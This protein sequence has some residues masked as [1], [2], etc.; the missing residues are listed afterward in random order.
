MISKSRLASKGCRGSKIIKKKEKKKE[1][2][3]SILEFVVN[4]VVKC[5]AFS[6]NEEKKGMKIQKVGRRESL[7]MVCH[8]K[9]NL[10]SSLVEAS[11]FILLE[12]PIRSLPSKIKDYP[13]K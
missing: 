11:A 8:F 6:K 7:S 10:R 4:K 13:R 1:K 9:H 12:P 2:M 5:M 3:K